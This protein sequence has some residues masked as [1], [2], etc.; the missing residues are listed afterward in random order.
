MVGA[1]VVRDGTAVGVGHHERF[2]GPHAE[3]GALNAAGPDARGATLYV[4]LEPC[5]HFGKTPPCTDAI[6][7]AGIARV[8]AATADPFPR[9]AGGGLAR[10]RD[11]GLAVEVGL[12][13]E[14]ARRL[15]APYFKRLVTGRPYV[16]AKW[17]MTLDGKTA[18]AAGDSKWISGPRSRALVHELR[19]RVDGIIAGIDTVVA[20][21]P[22]LTA[23]PPGPRQAARIVL[24]SEARLPPESQLA[25]SALAVPVWL[26]VTDRAPRE[27]K[28]SLAG[29][30]CEIIELAGNPRVMIGPLL[31]E[32]GRRGLTNVLVEGGGRV[33]GSFFDEGEVDE[34]DVY[35]APL[36]EGGDGS[37]SP[38]R[39]LGRSVMNDAVRLE[40]REI[41][42]IEGDVRVRGVVPRQ[43]R[44]G[45]WGL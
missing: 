22:Q 44:M 7:A 41:S 43:W 3:V 37:P 21:D 12:E 6:L 32:L 28:A 19:G 29:L 11:A 5:C 16:I 8:V 20:D 24:D 1:V 45:D 9:V 4:T 25:R 10:L 27:R 33:L 23:R 30:G 40:D 42:L 34:V 38:L 15:N 39:G 17:A 26:A 35:I 36:L 2:G 18:T 31:D 14:S 13:A